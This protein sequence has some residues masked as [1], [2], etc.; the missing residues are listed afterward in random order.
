MCCAI[1]PL[2]DTTSDT[3]SPSGLCY[4]AG[5]KNWWRESCT[6][7]TWKDSNCIK[8]FVNGTGFGGSD[9]VVLDPSRSFC[10]CTHGLLG[11]AIRQCQ[12]TKKIH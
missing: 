7:R 12:L 3:C 4:N 5:A 6:D 8:L 11:W 1:G 2:R 9:D 10:F